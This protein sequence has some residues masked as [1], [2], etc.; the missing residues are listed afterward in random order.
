MMITTS[1]T[2]PTLVLGE[3]QKWYSGIIWVS[4][5]YQHI[6]TFTSIWFIDTLIDILILDYLS[7]VCTIDRETLIDILILDYLVCAYNWFWDSKPSHTFKYV[8]TQD[9]VGW[10]S[11]HKEG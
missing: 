11:A 5:M 1:P 9:E 8:D 10:K 4:F 6:W 2:S 3:Y 7:Y